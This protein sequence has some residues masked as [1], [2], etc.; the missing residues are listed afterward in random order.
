VI[1]ESFSELVSKPVA[2]VTSRRKEYKK[3]LTR[4]QQQNAGI[5]HPSCEGGVPITPMSPVQSVTDLAGP[6]LR[7]KGTLKKVLDAIY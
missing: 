4:I 2:L 1:S 5:A 3:S 7:T 6:D